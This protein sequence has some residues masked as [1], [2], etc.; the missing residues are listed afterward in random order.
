MQDNKENTSVDS[1]KVTENVIKFDNSL[2]GQNIMAPVDYRGELK[3]R[4]NGILEKA[5]KIIAKNNLV[6]GR[7]QRELGKLLKEARRTF[8]TKSEFMKW[9]RENFSQHLRTL[10]EAQQM[11]GMGKFAE[12]FESIPKNSLLA[13]ARIRHEDVVVEFM[14]QNPPPV[15]NPDEDPTPRKNY[16]HT[17]IIYKRF[18]DQGITLTPEMAE[19]IAIK[20]NKALEIK[21]VKEVADEIHAQPTEELKVKVIQNWLSNGCIIKR[22]KKAKKPK[23]FGGILAQFK[24]IPEKYNL[25][26]TEILNELNADDIRDAYL[27]IKTLAEKINIPLS[28]PNQDDP[29]SDIADT[30]ES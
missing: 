25:D 28:L 12:E 11:A 19:A 20:C 1:T 17:V 23:G 26:D 7:N 27:L 10:E 4:I 5:S 9:L 14:E 16:A 24:G 15:V 21:A 13:F 2:T 22:E 8:N 18:Y 29:E 3:S 30:D 6:Y